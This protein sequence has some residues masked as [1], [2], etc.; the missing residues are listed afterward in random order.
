MECGTLAGCDPKHPNCARVGDYDEKIKDDDGSSPRYV[1]RPGLYSQAR[2]IV[3]HLRNH[4]TDAALANYLKARGCIVREKRR[5]L[6]KSGWEFPDLL[7]C[8]RQWERRFPG[9]PW[10]D[11]EIKEWRAEDLDDT[12]RTAK[13]KLYDA[14]QALKEAWRDVKAAR[15]AA[16]DDARLDSRT[17]F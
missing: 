1:R 8:R 4:T 9:W 5:V 11:P 15:R 14:R 12:I 2:K 17:R 7:D 16:E 3:P 13:G 10:R 6:R